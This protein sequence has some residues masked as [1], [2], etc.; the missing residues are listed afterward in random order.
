[1]LGSRTC[2]C[3]ATCGTPLGVIHDEHM[4]QTMD[5]LIRGF[6]GLAALADLTA[7]AVVEAGCAARLSREINRLRL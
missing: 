1:M 7:I 4:K 2:V 6:V 3:R 5:I